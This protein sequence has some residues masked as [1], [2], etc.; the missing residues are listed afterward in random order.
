MTYIP[1]I[2]KKYPY[3]FDYR[4]Q[5]ADNFQISILNYILREGKPLIIPKSHSQWDQRTVMPSEL[6]KGLLNPRVPHVLLRLCILE[7]DMLLSLDK[8]IVVAILRFYNAFLDQQFPNV[9]SFD[10]YPL[11]SGAS[12]C[13]VVRSQ[14]GWK[15]EALKIFSFFRLTSVKGT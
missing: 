5:C 7:N 4:R 1:Y 3:K 14:T 9:A 6:T 13:S 15:Y 10:L 11:A 12:F 2:C 8:I